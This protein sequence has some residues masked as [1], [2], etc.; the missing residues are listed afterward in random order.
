MY[1]EKEPVLKNRPRAPIDAELLSNQ[2]AAPL[3]EARELEKA[4]NRN[5]IPNGPL[6]EYKYHKSIALPEK[7]EEIPGTHWMQIHL[8]PRANKDEK[9]R[10]II[11]VHGNKEPLRSKNPRTMLSSAEYV[12]SKI[13]DANPRGVDVLEF[14][15]AE[16]SVGGEMVGSSPYSFT[17]DIAYTHLCNVLEAALPKDGGEGKGYFEGR[18]Y[19]EAICYGYSYGGGVLSRAIEEKR[20]PRLNRTVFGDAI[21]F[22][23]KKAEPIT[24]A[25]ASK[26]HLH[27]IQLDPDKDKQG[28]IGRTLA[29]ISTGA[30]VLRAF[31]KQTV[32]QRVLKV[33]DL[34][35]EQKKEVQKVGY[36]VTR[37]HTL[38]NAANPDLAKNVYDQVV[39]FLLEGKLPDWK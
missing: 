21:K 4:K 19:D 24:R 35:E 26:E 5:Y 27:F 9:Q 23:S 25:P 15:I 33:P 18:T 3:A 2:A 32:H 39:L 34:T 30:T 11:I 17:Q 28:L 38:N 20:I 12:G 14:R 29:P 7:T 36:G 1:F 31:E 6:Q 22:K 10:L 13:K 16:T 37:H 8:G